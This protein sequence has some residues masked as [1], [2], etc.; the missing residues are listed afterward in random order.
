MTIKAKTKDISN[1]DSLECESE[2]ERTQETKGE[3]FIVST[4]SVAHSSKFCASCAINGTHDESRALRSRR[5]P[6]R[7]P[8]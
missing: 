6:A 2:K 1:S 8:T 7:E 4:Q 3:E 5:E